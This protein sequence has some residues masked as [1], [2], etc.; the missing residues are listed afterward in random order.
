MMNH[1]RD[2]FAGGSSVRARMRA[3]DWSMSPLG[4]PSTWLPS[5]RTITALVLDA[6]SPMFV[7][8]GRD[9]G[10]LYN[11]P[12]AATLGAKHPAALGQRFSDIWP[13]IW[14][15][16]SPLVEAAVASRATFREDL[17]L[18]INRRGYDQQTW[19]TFV[20][21]PVGDESGAV[22]GMFCGSM[23]EAAGALVQA[24]DLQYRWRAINAAA[25]DERERSC[26]AGPRV[27]HS[28][29][30]LLAG[31]PKQQAA[32]KVV[33]CRALAGEEF[34]AID[35]FGGAPRARRGYAMRSNT[36]RDQERLHAGEEALRRRRQWSRLAN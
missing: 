34:K 10:F 19:L 27:G 3:H 36:L 31:E 9:L 35:E 23:I 14:S 33:W 2:H 7:A 6:Q 16:I 1:S 12:Y 26:G 25:A 22:A 15:D 32:K 11:D 13:E 28:M 20:Y 4:E 8:W 5:L 21:S 17:P 24:A 18:V 30:D 29:F